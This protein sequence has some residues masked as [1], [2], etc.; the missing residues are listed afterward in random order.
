[1]SVDPYMRG[2]MNDVKS[3]VAAVRARRDDGGRRGRRGRRRPAPTDVAVGALVLHGLG[4]RDVAVLPAAHVPRCSRLPGLPAVG[5]P[6][7]A[8]HARADRVGRPLRLARHARRA[9][10][11]FVSGAAGAVGSLVG[12]FARL[13]GASRVIGS[14]GLGGE[15]RAGCATTRLRRRVRLQGRP[16]APTS[17]PPPPRTASTS[18]STTSAASTSRRRSP[19][20]GRYGRAALCGVDLELQRDRAR[21]R[22]RATWSLVVG[23]RL[24]LRGLHRGRPRRPAA[25]VRRGGV[26]A[27]CAT[28]SWSPGRPSSRGSTP[29]STPSGPC[30]AAGT[31]G[32]WSSGS[33][34]T[35]ADRHPCSDPAPRRPTGPTGPVD[36]RG[37]RAESRSCG[38]SSPAGSACGSS[39][40]CSP[41]SAPSVLRRTRPDP[42]EAQRPDHASAT[43]CSRPVTLGE[44]ARVTD[45]RQA[46]PRALTDRAGPGGRRR[47]HRPTDHGGRRERRRP[48]HP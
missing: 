45:G 32:R 44:R 6:R 40:P 22:G 25:G 19:R 24:S 8:G 39:S 18:T 47:A 43:G 9:T 41:R 14:A 12:Q 3:Y 36:R 10:S 38:S 11:V 27:G 34:P 4:W 5:L 29:P 28:G 42:G 15:G 21:R 33:P 13:R 16:G 31:P 20:S 2:R 30:S 17:S 7:R 37:E 35:R 48:P 1:M 23:K 46:A 26:A